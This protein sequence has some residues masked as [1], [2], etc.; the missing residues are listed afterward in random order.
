VSANSNE[1]KSETVTSDPAELSYKTGLVVRQPDSATV[2]RL[3]DEL[4]RYDA[5]ERAETFD[6]LKRALNETRASIRAE[7]IYRNE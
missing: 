6:H 5:G 2:S 4:E 3:F 1:E 7:P